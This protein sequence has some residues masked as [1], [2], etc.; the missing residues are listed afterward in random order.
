MMQ[1]FRVL[2][3][4]LNSETDRSG[5]IS[6]FAAALFTTSQ[7]LRRVGGAILVK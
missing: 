3:S 2:A 5:S 1:P 7:Q 6:I 4:E